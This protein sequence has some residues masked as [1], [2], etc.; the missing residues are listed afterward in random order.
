MNYNGLVYSNTAVTSTDGVVSIGRH[1]SSIKLINTHATIN[2]TVRLNGG[3]SSVLIPAINSGGGYVELPGDYTSFE[4]L[5]SSV[6]L[7][8]IAFG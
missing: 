6:T 3:P 5:T 1:T 4:I 7:A 8:V 2:A